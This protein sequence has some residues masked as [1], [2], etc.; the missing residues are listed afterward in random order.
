[1]EIEMEMETEAVSAE[2]QVEEA[3]PVLRRALAGAED[4]SVI[5]SSVGFLTNLAQLLTSP[6]DQHSPLTGAQLISLKVRT[7]HSRCARY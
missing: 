6:P 1:M 5:I 2:L 7:K 3:V 4:Q